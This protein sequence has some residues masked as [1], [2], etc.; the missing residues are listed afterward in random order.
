LV[1]ATREDQCHHRVKIVER[2]KTAFG[3]ETSCPVVGDDFSPVASVG[4][5]EMQSPE[6]TGCVQQLQREL[7]RRWMNLRIIERQDIREHSAIQ[8][9]KAEMPP[10][11]KSEAVIRSPVILA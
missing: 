2:I 1:L 3:L 7:R 9:E 10:V 11:V 8:I 6:Q 5:F 4:A